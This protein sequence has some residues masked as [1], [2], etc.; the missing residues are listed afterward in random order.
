MQHATRRKPDTAPCDRHAPDSPER[1][2]FLSA[3]GLALAGLA[4]GCSRESS[5]APATRRKLPETVEIAEFSNDGK[6][7]RVA[8]V[9]SVVKSEDEWRRQ[10]S[11]LA[12]RV[13]RQDGT[14]IAFTGALLKNKERG[15]YRCVCCETALFDSRTKYESGTGWPSFWRPISRHNI[16]EET[17][18]SLGMVRTEVSC[19]RCDAH[20]GHVF[21][22]GPRPTGLR[23]CMNSVSLTFAKA[24]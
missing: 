12:Y 16:H 9:P 18:R 21:N 24:A 1:R 5:A 4:L 7:L 8:K 20:L 15:V 3:S 17:D 23:Y 10:L 6:R 19:A 2:G 13:T 14:E 11:P 22:D